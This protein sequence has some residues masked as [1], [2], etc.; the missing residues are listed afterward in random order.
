MT[1]M[2][3]SA[4]PTA[5]VAPPRA[6]RPVP[7]R[8]PAMGALFD[9]LRALIVLLPGRDVPDEADEADFDNMPV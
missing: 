5:A 4:R 6:D 2:A 8:D 3:A 7:P 1:T 9:E